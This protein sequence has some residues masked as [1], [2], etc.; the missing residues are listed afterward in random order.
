M[1]HD[2]VLAP[3]PNLMK[4]LVIYW[5]YMIVPFQIFMKNSIMWFHKKLSSWGFLFIQASISGWKSF[6]CQKLWS[7]ESNKNCI[8]SLVLKN[9]FM[10]FLKTLDEMKKPLAPK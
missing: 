3:L 2:W 6:F 8:K 7:L 9:H 4:Y 1:A 10:H 5:M